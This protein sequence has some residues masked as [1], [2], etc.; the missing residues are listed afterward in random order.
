MKS[1][2]TIGAQTVFN[3]SMNYHIKPQGLTL[4][5]TAANLTDKTYIVS[6]VNGI[7]VNAH[8]K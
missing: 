1:G 8:G 5:L 3:A 2:A 6:R 7:H 4:S